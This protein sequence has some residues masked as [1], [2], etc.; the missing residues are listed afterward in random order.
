VEQVADLGAFRFVVANESVPFFKQ[1]P[2]HFS[3]RP[4]LTG[5]RPSDYGGEP[6]SIGTNDEVMNGGLSSKKF[7]AAVGKC[8]DQ[9][10]L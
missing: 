10:S 9:K 3:Q 1:P 5:K 6:G 4:C 7:S 2:C 8:V